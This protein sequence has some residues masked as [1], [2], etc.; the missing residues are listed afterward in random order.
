MCAAL[1]MQPQRWLAN[2]NVIFAP[3]DLRLAADRLGISMERGARSSNDNALH[4]ATLRIQ[5][6]SGSSEWSLLWLAREL[7]RAPLPMGWTVAP[8]ADRNVNGV[9]ASEWQALCPSF[10]CAD[11]HESVDQHP[12]TA[13]LKAEVALMRRRLK[14]RMRYF[15]KLES[16]C[17][18]P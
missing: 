1:Q 15:R 3:A 13:T 18:T 17:G 12:L 4:A 7:L 10:S 6:P 2:P 5:A 14:L 11:G 16:V 8:P 9:H